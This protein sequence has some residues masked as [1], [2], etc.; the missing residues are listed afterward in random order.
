[1]NKKCSSEEHKEKDANFY[2]VQCQVNM[3]NNCM[4][5][6]SKLLKNHKVVSLDKNIDEIFTGFCKEKNHNNTILNYFCK[7]HNQLCCAECISKIKKD[8]IGKHHDCEIDLIENIK[9]EKFNTL[10]N[11]IKNLEQLSKNINRSINEL[12]EIYEKINKSKEE[13]KQKIMKIFTEI[14]DQLNNREDELLLEIDKIY[15]DLYF[16][17]ELINESKNLS[18]KIKTNVEKGKQININNNSISII[19]DCINIENNIKDINNININKE[20]SKRLINLNIMFNNNKEK[21][22]KEIIKLF[23]KIEI[24]KDN[25]YKDFNIQYKEPIHKLNFHKDGVLCLTILNDGRLASGSRDKNII[26][27][28]K[29]SFR[30]DIIIKEHSKNQQN[31]QPYNNVCCLIQLSSGELVTCSQEI[32]ILKI[33]DL[34][35]EIIQI[36]KDNT[37]YVLKLIELKN[38]NLASCSNDSSVIFYY[39]DNSKY[40]IK[41]KINTNGGCYTIIQTK[42]NEICCSTGNNNTICFYDFIEKKIKSS[43]HNISKTHRS[44]SEFIM[45]SE[46]LLLIP[47]ENKISIINVNEY[48]LI[49]IIEVPG[50]SWILGVCFLSDDMII[51]GSYSKTIYQWKIEKDNLILMSKKEKVHDNN[52][53]VLYNLGNGYIASGSDDSSIYIW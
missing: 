25:L 35:Y 34:N 41:F 30:P 38:K 23:G 28:N 10:Q 21:E 48:K 43:L 40:K 5:F 18:N 22:I 36:L 2:C 12:K 17:E 13:L 45:I 49:K 19:N 33:N 9:N 42:E 27:Y 37:N 50:A 53:S 6:H 46:C 14:R 4:N 1:M 44:C 24:K 26:I 39:K 7:R 11:N 16:K 3:C 51:A 29:I 47:G 31:N 8:N 15:D 20:K 52:I 32:I